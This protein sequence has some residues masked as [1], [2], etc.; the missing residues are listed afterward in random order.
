MKSVPIPPSDNIDTTNQQ[1]SPPLPFPPSSPLFSSFHKMMVHPCVW[2]LGLVMCLINISFVMIFSLSALYLNT[3]LNVGL[4]LIN[5]LEGVV[6]G[7]SFIMKLFSG[8]ISDYF[9]RRK[10]IMLIGFFFTVISKPIFAM[11]T[12]FVHVFFARLFE[13]V[14]NGIQSTPR[15]AMVGDVAPA[16]HRASNFGLLR[17][18]GTA[19]SCLGGLAGF[20]AMYYTS[21]N[22]QHVFFLATI[23][24]LLAFLILALFVKEPKTHVSQDGSIVKTRSDRR[25]IHFKDLKLLGRNYWL[26]MIVVAIFMMARF[27]ETQLVLHA[28]KNFG[29][30]QQNA[31]LIMFLYNITYSIF[32]YPSGLIAD[33]FGRKIVLTMGICALILSDFLLFTATGLT[34]IFVG[35]FLWGIQLASVHNTFVSL[36]TDYVPD[37][38]RGT[39]LGF[40]YL[41][42]A[43]GSIFVGI[44]NGSITHYYGYTGMFGCSMIIAICALLALLILLPNKQKTTKMTT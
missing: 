37:D 41:V 6:E 26:L 24:A 42:G 10:P 29:L 17:T 20:A 43:M 23:P 9:R 22:F 39:S 7:I 31:P 5:L 25:P 2:L 3:N 36:I 15:D 32:S 11:S 14:G 18:L 33:R 40:Y 44:F 27:S 30:E 28:H 38:L 12:N 35:I 21:S 16:T 13:R 19:G 1:S 4:F 8:V 34:Q